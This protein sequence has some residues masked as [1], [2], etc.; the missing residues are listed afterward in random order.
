MIEKIKVR[1]GQIWRGLRR[2]SSFHRVALEK[3][4]RDLCNV[5]TRVIG[6]HD[7][8]SIPLSDLSSEPNWSGPRI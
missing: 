3:I 6:V 1:R 7:E 4:Q 5:R 8:S 2:R